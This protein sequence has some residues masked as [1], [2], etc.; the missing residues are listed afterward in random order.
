[1]TQEEIISMAREAGASQVT[2]P[3]NADRPAH[4]FSMTHLERF[5]KLVAEKE[6]EA[7]AKEIEDQW[8]WDMNDP[9]ATACRIIRAR[10][11]Q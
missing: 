1:M 7:C 2:T 5:A 4:S 3:M 6:R 8:T 9:A 11:E 10:G